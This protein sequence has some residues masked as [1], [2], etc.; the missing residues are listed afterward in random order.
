MSHCVLANYGSVETCQ[1]W[2][3]LD[4]KS[5]EG[6]SSLQIGFGGGRDQEFFR[7]SNRVSIRRPIRWAQSAKQLPK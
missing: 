4:S 6:I 5:M 2:N 3:K 7:L 1:V